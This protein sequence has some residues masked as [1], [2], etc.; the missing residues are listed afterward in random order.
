MCRPGL[1]MENGAFTDDRPAVVRASAVRS[2][3]TRKESD[4]DGANDAPAAV[5]QSILDGHV[6][7]LLMA[8]DPGLAVV[9]EAQRAS[10]GC[11][12]RARIAA[13]TFTGDEADLDGLRGMIGVSRRREPVERS[14]CGGDR[15][16]CVVVHVHFAG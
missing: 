16:G 12:F 3:M 4:A 2:L 13:S 9:A 8:A 11:A 1:Y 15:Y 7:T 6:V 5:A 14:C 10:S